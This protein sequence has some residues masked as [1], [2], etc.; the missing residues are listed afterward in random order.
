MITY[1][2]TIT[3]IP[4]YPTD[5]NL[6]DVVFAA[7]YTVTAREGGYEA[8]EPSCIALAPPTGQFTPYA[9]LTQDQVVGWVKDALGPDGVAALEA[10]LANVL[11][12][13]INPT[14]AVN[15]LPWG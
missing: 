4:C 8:S 3:E 6:Q 12:E 10:N 5:G 13:Q 11:A 9:D 7:Y 15:P 1:E 14:V 2:W